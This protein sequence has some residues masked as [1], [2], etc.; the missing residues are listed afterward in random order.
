MTVSDGKG[1]TAE[2]TFSIILEAAPIVVELDI[3]LIIGLSILGFVVI[4]SII[5]YVIWRKKFRK[6]GPE[7]S[8]SDAGEECDYIETLSE[9]VENKHRGETT[10]RGILSATESEG[11]K[12]NKRALES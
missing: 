7:V 1:G 5:G 3:A 2:E 9:D 11:I 8:S 4:A 6:I 10:D 12:D